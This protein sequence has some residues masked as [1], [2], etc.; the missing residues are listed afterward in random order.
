MIKNA[1]ML[2]FICVA[3]LAFFLPAYLKM[4]ALNEK[5]R[6][7][8]RK[9]VALEKDNT[10]SVEERRRLVEDPEYFE[11][12]AREKL[13]I[14]KDDEVIYKVL[15]PGQK[16]S[17]ASADTSGLIKTTSESLVEALD[18]FPDDPIE[19]ALKTATVKKTTAPTAA[20][21]T[22]PVKKTTATAG[23]ITTTPSKTTTVK[24]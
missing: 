19:P 16:R 20:K 6:A 3:V 10:L 1:L 17:A 22:A 8:E 23:K 5:N 12:V 15:P 4:Q 13:G 9:I 21:M 7:Y 14:I 24:K 2:F 11:M 18:L